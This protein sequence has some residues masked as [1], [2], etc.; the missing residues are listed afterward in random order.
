MALSEPVCT[1]SARSVFVEALQE[2]PGV[3][4]YTVLLDT[5]CLREPRAQPVGYS[6]VEGEDSFLERGN[7]LSKLI[8]PDISE[9]TM[10]LRHQIPV[11]NF[12]CDSTLSAH[13]KM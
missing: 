4:P 6:S 9:P 2:L 3:L 1:P 7:P 12:P 13:L 8:I 10:K 11:Q 5:Q